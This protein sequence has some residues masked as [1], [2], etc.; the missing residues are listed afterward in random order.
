MPFAEFWTWLEG[1]P[2][3][4]HIGFTW[5]FPLLE[6]IHVLAVAL[7]VGTILTVDLRLLGIAARRYPASRINR[8]LIPWTWGAFCVAV[9]TGTG[10]F[11]TRASTY[12]ENPAFETKLVLLMLAGVNMAWFQFRTFRSIAHWDTAAATPVSA[13]VAGATS[14]LLWVGVVLAGRWVGHII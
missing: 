13:R 2:L 4:E 5:W 11:M 14:L 6:S 10:M 9:V 12:I 3:S 8:E 7:V 1:L